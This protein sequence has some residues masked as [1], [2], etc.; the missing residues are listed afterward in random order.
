MNLLTGQ[1]VYIRDGKGSILSKVKKVGCRINAVATNL[2]AAFMAS[3]MFHALDSI[4]VFD[5][6]H[7]VKLMNDVLD[8]ICRS[9]YWEEMD[10]NKLKVVKRTR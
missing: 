7:V 5:H 2:L 10:L 9:V 1:V 3:V 4:L 8:E 6:F